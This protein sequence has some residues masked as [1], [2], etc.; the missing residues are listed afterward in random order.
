MIESKTALKLY[1]RYRMRRLAAQ[2]PAKVQEKELLK[3]V[4]KAE[5]TRFGNDHQFPAIK[6]VKD[7][8][9]RVPLWLEDDYVRVP[10]RLSTV[11]ATFTHRTVL[12]PKGA[13]GSGP[14]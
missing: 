2:D 13:A 14:R 11:R 12:I 1:A 7:Y 5:E 8:H 9:E 4:K 6:S 10:L 3:L